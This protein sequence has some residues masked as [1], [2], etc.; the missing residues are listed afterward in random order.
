M[1]LTN[2]THMERV[3]PFR[4]FRMQLAF[5]QH[6]A[7][8]TGLVQS[9]HSTHCTAA[10]RTPWVGWYDILLVCTTVPLAY[11]QKLNLSLCKERLLHNIGIRFKVDSL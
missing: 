11:Q 9:I 3:K 6:F 7:K 1:K 5:V 8:E 2:G 4:A 10:V